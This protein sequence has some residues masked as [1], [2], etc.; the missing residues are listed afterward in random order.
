MG[1]QPATSQGARIEPRPGAPLGAAGLALAAAALLAAAYALGS[2]TESDPATELGL[3]VA[4]VPLIGASALFATRRPAWAMAAMLA[5]AAFSG[6]LDANFRGIPVRPLVWLFLLGVLGATVLGLL[7]RRRQLAL[8]PG[9]LALG[10]YLAFTALQIPFAETTYIGMQAF[11]VA[12]ALIIAFFAVAYADWDDATRRRVVGA[13]LL[14]AAAVGV[15]AA[16]RLVV[17][18][19]DAEQQIARRSAAVAGDLSLFASFGNRVELGAWCAVATPFLF[20]LVLGL[21]G[22]RR[23]L[24]GAAL[25]L[26]VVALLG[27]E[28]RTALVGAALGIGAALL[29]YQA[30]RAFR[31]VR[32]GTTAIAVVGLL[33]AGVIGFAVTVGTD[34]TSSERFAKILDPGDDYSLQQ[35]TRKWEEAVSEINAH[36]YGQGLGTAGSTQRRY[37]HV[38]RLD[39]KFIDNAWLQL[40]VQQGYPGLILF[41]LSLVLILYMLARASVATDDPLRAA[42]GIGAAGALVA[43]MITLMTGNILETWSALLIWV[44]LGLAANGF[45][46]SRPA[47]LR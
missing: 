43:W 29:L 5:V 9:I 38:Y 42:V 45:L 12:P 14:L 2:S 1:I 31:V 27:S 8:W 36:P 4:A 47:S 20:A 35:R 7:H 30:A 39:N 23:L 44:L 25:A 34:S 24:A 11:A 18:P 6:T 15:Y 21:R 26:T 37:S 22:R 32:L 28:V 41:A 40:G 19:T 46:A 3:A 17:G 16:F 13:F 10:A 33:A